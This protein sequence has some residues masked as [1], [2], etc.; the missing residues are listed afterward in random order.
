[1]THDFFEYLELAA[2]AF[3]LHDYHTAALELD[4]AL[5]QVTP[6]EHPERSP[7]PFATDVW[8]ELKKAVDALAAG[9][10]RISSV[11]LTKAL[12]KVRPANLDQTV[13]I[14]D[15]RRIAER[16][17]REEYSGIS[18]NLRHIAKL[19][20]FQGRRVMG[21]AKAAAKA[22]PVSI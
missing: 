17:R 10:F 4:R 7:H 16:L 20:E 5:E 13:A 15:A 3:D 9:D 19:L 11:C 18:S 21:P 22:D 2:Q 6:R 14:T 1:M 12:R 8:S